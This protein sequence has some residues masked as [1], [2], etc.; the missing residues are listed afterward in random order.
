MRVDEFYRFVRGSSLLEISASH[1]RRFT[2][3]IKRA[4]QLS[5][6][7]NCLASVPHE[8]TK[9]LPRRRIVAHVSG[10]YT[11]QIDSSQLAHPRHGVHEL[12]GRGGG[13]GGRQNQRRH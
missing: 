12:Q 9:R 5:P 7:H 1:L 13:Q 8:Y 10:L 4:D 2:L 11:S 6:E 3:V